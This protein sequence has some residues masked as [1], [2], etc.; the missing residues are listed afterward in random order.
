M[1]Q[2]NC[3]DDYLLENEYAA[4]RPLQENDFNNL[5]PFSLNEPELWKYSLV[6][7]AGEED[8]KSYMQIALNAR[9][10]QKEYSFIFF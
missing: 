5:L 1:D 10:E 3:T 4:L 2:F 7:A 8:L 9:L 6:T